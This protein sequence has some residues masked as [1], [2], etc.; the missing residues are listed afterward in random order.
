MNCKR[1]SHP[2]ESPL[3]CVFIRESF[4][5][6]DNSDMRDNIG[7]TPAVHTH[8]GWG[9]PIS[10]NAHEKS[11]RHE[12]DK[13]CRRWAYYQSDPIGYFVALEVHE[14]D[15]GSS[16][17][18]VFGMGLPRTNVSNGLGLGKL[19]RSRMSATSLGSGAGWEPDLP[20]TERLSRTLRVLV[21]WKAKS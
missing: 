5:F 19:M 11:S 7:L 17:D 6:L 18:D 20:P 13:A 14:S 21:A 15:G 8:L 9:I 16:E 2:I 1:F 10:T 12:F 4:P 3:I